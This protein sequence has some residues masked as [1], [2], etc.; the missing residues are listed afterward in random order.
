MVKVVR[1][2]L[3]GIQRRYLVAC[4]FVAVAIAA[5]VAPV[6]AMATGTPAEE[7]ATE[8][9]TKVS[10]EGDGAV[11]VF[12]LGVIGLIILIVVIFFI[13]KLIRRVMH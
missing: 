1:V 11:K 10:T 4:S 9:A 3:A 12:A 2:A 5:A 8:A 7:Y 6:A 13:W